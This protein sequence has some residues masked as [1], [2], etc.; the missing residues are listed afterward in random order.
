MK[1]DNM[2][3]TCRICSGAYDVAYSRGAMLKHL[4]ATANVAAYHSLTNLESAC[5]D[6]REMIEAS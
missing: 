5:Q 1:A 6:M 4:Q 2:A 3:S